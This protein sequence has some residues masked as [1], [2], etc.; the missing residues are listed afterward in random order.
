MTRPVEG[1]CG[2][3]RYF[4]N[5]SATLE[6]SFSGLA[7]MGSGFA[8][9]RASDGICRLKGLYLSARAGCRHF[10][11]VEP[12]WRSAPGLSAIVGKL[13]RAITASFRKSGNA[14]SL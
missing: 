7:A 6:A 12:Q 9:V 5:N 14:A 1:R 4:D 2:G 10:K 13:V 8:S 3:C 11:A